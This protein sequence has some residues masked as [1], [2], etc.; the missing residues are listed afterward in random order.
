ML[1]LVIHLDVSDSGQDGSVIKITY[2]ISR[3]GLAV[4][5]SMTLSLTEKI[6]KD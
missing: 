5:D 3:S 6:H 2:H 4:V 1:L